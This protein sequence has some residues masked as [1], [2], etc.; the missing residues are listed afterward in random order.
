MTGYVCSDV[1]IGS[2]T[3]QFQLR[4][5]NSKQLDL[6]LN[7]HE[8]LFPFDLTIRN[9][10][11]QHFSRGKINLNISIVNSK[12][13]SKKDLD[14]VN[15]VIKSYQKIVP[16]LKISLLELEHLMSDSIKIDINEKL[17]EQKLHELCAS[18]NKVKYKEGS[19]LKKLIKKYLQELNKLIIKIN[20]STISNI[21]KM[22]S[23]LNRNIK[24]LLTKHKLEPARLEQEALLYIMRSDITEEIE[25][26]I[27]HISVI[28]NL[29]SEREPIGKKLDFYCQEL[30][31]EVNTISAKSNHS[32]IPG[33]VV[34]CK[35]LIDKIREQGQNIE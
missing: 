17:F 22:K 21:D 25:R 30:N 15:K 34:E 3:L 2:C 35:F 33:F 9:I 28:N 16:N 1:S 29:L 6:N 31:R 19:S 7:L 32:K 26:T 20:K 24:S 8:R 4:S 10:F 13:S 23:K 12:A 5:L 14:K 11:R 18:L 27:L